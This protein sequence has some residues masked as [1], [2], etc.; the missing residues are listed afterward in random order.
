MPT[1]APSAGALAIDDKALHRSDDLRDWGLETAHFYGTHIHLYTL[2][3]RGAA[4]EKQKV[5]ESEPARSDGAHT[6]HATSSADTRARRATRDTP[7][8]GPRGP[9]ARH[10]AR[11]PGGT[12]R[13]RLLLEA[14]P[15]KVD[16]I[17]K[18]HGDISRAVGRQWKALSAEEKKKW[19][20][21]SAADQQRYMDECKAA[22]IEPKLYPHIA[23]QVRIARPD[24]LLNGETENLVD[25]LLMGVGRSQPLGI[26]YSAEAKEAPQRVVRPEQ[27]PDSKPL[28]WCARTRSFV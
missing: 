3:R 28:R 7:L 9:T 1:A 12:R 17:V 5:P 16:D 8:T 22:G 11:P 26:G 14:R 24:R 15:E 18:Q 27:K 21:A 4:C 23:G 6:R 13:R 2:V 20:E 19:A 25:P 10:A